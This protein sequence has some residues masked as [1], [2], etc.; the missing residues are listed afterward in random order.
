M[1]SRAEELRGEMRYL[2]VNP[3]LEQVNA[4]RWLKLPGITWRFGGGAVC[5]EKNFSLKNS[6]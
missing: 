3:V 6:V 4:F 2:Q 5:A 1:G